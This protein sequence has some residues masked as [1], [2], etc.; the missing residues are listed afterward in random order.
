MK[1]FH[2]SGVDHSPNPLR[3]SPEGE[4]DRFEMEEGN[5]ACPDI[6]S[7]RTIPPGFY[8]V[9]KMLVPL[10]H[11][12]STLSQKV[13]S[14]IVT[15]KGLVQ[16]VGF[17]PFI[18]RIACRYNLSGWVK[19]TN[20]CVLIRIQGKEKDIHEFIQAVRNEKP[21]AS[22]IDL[23][24]KE[25]QP[26]EE[27]DGFRIEE[28]RNVSDEITDISP[29]IAVCDD[30]LEDMA[31]QE[32][33]LKYPFIN[34]TNCGPRFT[35]IKD[36]PYD[37][38][39]TSMDVFPMCDA[40]RNE[41]EDVHDRRFHAQPVACLGCGPEY[42]YIK[43][44]SRVEEIGRIIDECR[45]L[46]LSGGILA[47]K[48]I[49][50]FHLA[51]DATS[52]H[53]VDR[54]RKVKNREGKPFAVMFRDVETLRRFA[55]ISE[56]EEHSLLSW[57]RPIV[58]LKSTGKESLAAG[59]GVRLDT[60][61]VM[62]PY[63]PF[64]YLLFEN[65]TI[66]AIVLT[67]GNFSD[68]PILIDN[69]KAI[70]TF[71]GKTDAI[72]VYN[73]NIE[74]RTDDSVVRII[75]K[76]ER[77]LRRS[78]GYVPS[79]VN[80]DLNAEGI[81]ATGAE[82]VNTFCIGKG[83]KAILSQYIGNLESAETTAF[84]EETAEKFRKLFRVTPRIIVS[85]LHPDYFT[86]RYAAALGPSVRQVRV[87]HHHAHIASC[88]AENRLDEPVIGVAMDGTGFGTD[89]KIWGAE[90]LYCDL[91][92][93]ERFTHFSYL[94][95]PGGDRGTEE[96]WRIAVSYLHTVY[97]NDIH[98]LE[99]PFLR[100]LDPEKL[101]FILKM[102]RSGINCPM[103]SSTGRLFDAVAAL[104][105]LCMI[106]TFPAEAPMRLESIATPGFTERYK[107]MI[108]ETINVQSMIPGIVEDILAGVD[109]GIISAKF[110]NTIISVIFE[111]VNAMSNRF[112]CNKVV[113]SGGT[114]QNK[115]LLEGT[116]EMLG[117][118]GFDVY[119]HASVPTNDGGI[120]LGQLAIA[121]KRR[122]LLCV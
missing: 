34:C 69:Q 98:R 104:L 110:H 14:F 111:V 41:Y 101:D 53:A 84:Y 19:N 43:G 33:R 37:R 38:K 92:D 35:I 57:R 51:C 112:R 118:S 49:G 59:V 81:F 27:L 62:L 85:D 73:R 26:V 97:G 12:N 45:D 80:L 99:I 95:L 47:I 25:A 66:P 23:I 17:R 24:T 90:F 4:G 36:L 61:G 55:V 46:L 52:D 22:Q 68:E 15:V 83:N 70:D 31:L 3:P 28:S 16:G 100:K 1:N 114:F 119:S 50:G 103:V 21:A 96:P 76:K 94:P 29:D 115:Y 74:N 10:R 121:A 8:P 72:L 113:L 60:I 5:W 40:C 106:S 107:V 63:L 54:L 71:S 56:T 86:S 30:C 18:Y 2:L 48:G 93:F 44:D 117:E 32:N 116:L 20:E 67:S 78:R 82:L 77:I 88:M 6:Y 75:H 87:Q 64:H 109:P 13:K 89:G 9:N 7:H 58:L 91:N 65:F 42:T 122:E 105:G 39:N 108:D 102:L 79:P 120:S 11:C